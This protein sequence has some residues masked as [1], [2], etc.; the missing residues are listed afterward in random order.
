M[1]GIVQNV[2]TAYESIA[3]LNIWFKIQDGE[4][5]VLADFPGMLPFRWEYFR[6]KWEF[7]R[8]DYEQRVDTYQDGNL[9]KTNIAN[10][11][12]FV[13]AQRD[14][15]T[16]PFRRSRVIF[17]FFAL[18]DSTPLEEITLTRE[19]RSIVDDK[20]SEIKRYNRDD[21]LEMRAR[22]ENIRDQYADV[23][24]LSDPDYNRVYNRSSVS[25]Q[26]DATNIDMNQLFA[27]NQAIESINF[28]VA[29]QFSLSRSFVDPYALARSNAN[30]EEI[31]IR[32]Y[33][34]GRLVKMNYN[35][36]LRGLARQY[37]GDEDRW[38][39]I[40]IANGLKPP[41]IDEVGTV[42]PLVGNGKG[43]KV[44][45]AAFD[46]DGNLNSDRFF[47]G[48]VIFISSDTTGFP[49]QRTIIDIST[50]PVS[51][52][53][54]LEL[55]GEADLNL[56]TIDNN[57]HIRVFKPGTINSNFF[58]L[59]PSSEPTEDIREDI[60][61]WFLSTSS[62]S[63][64]KMKVDLRI[65]EDGELNFDNSSDFELSFGF[66]NAIQAMRLKMSV[67]EGELF[68]H[69]EFGLVNISGITNSDIAD[70]TQILADSI[71]EQVQA[72]VRF[73]RIESLDIEYTVN[74]QNPDAPAGFRVS[75]SVR[76][77]GSE[78]AIPI[79]FSIN[80]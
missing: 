7:I 39:E 59:I 2:T 78:Q 6:D 44:S 79:S 53:I 26:T 51:E 35:Q 65:D 68:K 19:E 64:K 43:N 17:D 4:P 13:E 3:D 52:D 15:D 50:I 49:E 27:I 38:I 61:P 12:N 21:F 75:M 18:F 72:D 77:A 47:I 30:N 76:L 16:N 32:T 45:I 24:G 25:Q 29:N 11:D 41:Y 46:E 69:D 40:A 56:Y 57:A 63:A 36:D 70:L 22:L 23:K 62:E 20:I 60:T 34:T 33:A 1:T 54:V 9:L 71:T 74:R 73:D 42:L 66:E 58:V 8:Q 28:I 31:D 14:S 48:Q 80:I 55:D 67:S 5:Y 10:F 37:M